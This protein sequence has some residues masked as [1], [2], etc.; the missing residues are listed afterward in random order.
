MHTRHFSSMSLTTWLKLSMDF[1]TPRMSLNSVC[2][3]RLHSI[4]NTLTHSETVNSA[5]ILP[6]NLHFL[7]TDL[8][9]CIVTWT[10][11]ITYSYTIWQPHKLLHIT[12]V[13][14]T[15]T[16]FAP[17]HIH[18]FTIH[19]GP[20]A[21]IYIY[22]RPTNVPYNIWVIFLFLQNHNKNAQGCTSVTAG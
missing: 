5:V 7:L 10:A 19:W 20:Q 17:V 18:Y 16:F 15:R 6:F 4:I 9:F 14:C 13:R 12:Y 11:V 22:S 8:D 21:N 2:T 3:I 1:A